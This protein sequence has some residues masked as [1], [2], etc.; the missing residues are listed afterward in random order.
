MRDHQDVAV[1]VA[2]EDLLDRGRDARLEK[3]R[4]LAARDE[5]PVGLVGPSRPGFGEPLPQLFGAQAFPL[6]EKDLPERGQRLG[7]D[8]DRPAQDGRGLECALEVAGVKAGPMPAGQPPA[9]Q[10]GLPPALLGEWRIELA[11]DAVLAVPGRLA[12][13]NQEQASGGWLGGER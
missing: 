2:T 13:A 3:R 6:A 1:L 12:V 5:V 8:S 10:L 9:Q 7:G 11:L 4:S